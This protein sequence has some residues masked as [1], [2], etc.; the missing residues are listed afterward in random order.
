MVAPPC[1]SDLRILYNIMLFLAQ[2]VLHFLPPNIHWINYWIV[3]Q[4]IWFLSREQQAPGSEEPISYFRV[5]VHRWF[6]HPL[7]SRQAFGTEYFFIIYIQSNN[8][9][10]SP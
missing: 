9:Y 6:S 8:M 5:P 4:L 10:H 2:R 1:L 7:A 3:L